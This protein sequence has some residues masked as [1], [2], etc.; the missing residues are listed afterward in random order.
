VAEDPGESVFGAIGVS[1]NEKHLHQEIAIRRFPDAVRAIDRRD[2]WREIPR[3]RGSAIR[4]F[5]SQAHCVEI[6]IR[7]FPTE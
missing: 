1:R 2:T 7:D 5:R 6:A 3:S 4:D